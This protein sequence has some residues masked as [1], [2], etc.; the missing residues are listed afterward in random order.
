MPLN[1]K[2]LRKV[3]KHI[4]EEPRRFFMWGVHQTGRP[5]K[6]TYKADGSHG[7]VKFPSCGTAACIAGWTCLLG[8][9]KDNVSMSVANQLLGVGGIATASL[10][11]ANYWPAPLASQFRTAKTPLQRAKIAAKRINLFIRE[12]K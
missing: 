2:L 10:Y 8:G 5:N 4:L 6:D 9:E 3:K 1:V 11:N 7:R 12:H